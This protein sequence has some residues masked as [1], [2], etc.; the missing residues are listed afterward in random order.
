MSMYAYV[1]SSLFTSDDV[2]LLPSTLF[3]RIHDLIADNHLFCSFK[4]FQIFCPISNAL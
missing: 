4:K 3:L 2:V 1:A